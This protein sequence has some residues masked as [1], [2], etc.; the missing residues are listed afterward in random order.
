MP[1][2]ID[3]IIESLRAEAPPETADRILE[4]CGDP[5]A[6]PTPATQRQWV[7]RLMEAMDASLDEPTRIRIMQNC[8]RQCLPTGYIAKAKALYESA[9]D[10]DDFLRELNKTGLGGGRLERRGQIIHGG[11]DRCYCGLVKGSKTPISLTYCNCSGGWY[12]RL[13]ESVLGK[14]VEVKVVDSIVHGADRCT[15]EISWQ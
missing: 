2:R 3:R 7:A 1:N 5:P 6:K 14:P 11:Y 12:Q 10:I 4:S 15:F 13:F 8:G 9:S